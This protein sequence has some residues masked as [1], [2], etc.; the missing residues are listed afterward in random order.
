MLWINIIKFIWN[1]YYNRW[2]MFLPKNG[3]GVYDRLLD[4]MVGRSTARKTKH[5]VVFYLCIVWTRIHWCLPLNPVHTSS[6]CYGSSM[7]N[8]VPITKISCFEKHNSYF[9]L[10]QQ[11]SLKLIYNCTKGSAPFACI[12]ISLAMLS[13]L[14]RCPALMNWQ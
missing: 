14:K 2:R 1:F 8:Y 6:V 11:P 7:K 3:S 9:L 10:F 13:F 5:E 4:L 12:E